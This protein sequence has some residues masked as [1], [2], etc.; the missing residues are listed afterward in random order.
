MFRSRNYRGRTNARLGQGSAGRYGADSF[1][2]P[3]DFSEERSRYKFAGLDLVHITP[4]PA[5]S[6]LDRANQRMLRFMEMLGRV[7]VLGRVATTNVPTNE[8][9]TQV[10]PRITGFGTFLADAF[11]GFFEFDLIKVGAFFWHQ[12]L[13]Y[14]LTNGSHLP[15]LQSLQLGHQDEGIERRPQGL[16]PACL[17][18]LGGTAEPVPFP[19]PPAEV[20][21][22]FRPCDLG[23]VTKGL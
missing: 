20:S 17:A 5:F 9:K 1:R 18:G 21:S 10:N 7:L 3:N 8:A 19:K 2:R 4:H 12:F 23:H 11:F 13:L 14:L 15:L 6:R 16:K 22:S